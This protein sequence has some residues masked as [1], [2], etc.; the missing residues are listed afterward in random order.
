M[1]SECLQ[2]WVNEVEYHLY[3]VHIFR[4]SSVVER[5]AVND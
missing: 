2:L 5:I 4:H 3:Q 1:A